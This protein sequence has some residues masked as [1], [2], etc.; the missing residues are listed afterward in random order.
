MKKILS[1][2]LT[3]MFLSACG[4]KA[5]APAENSFNE[6]K[7]EVVA[8]DSENVSNTS[9][10]DDKEDE[11]SKIAFKA[12]E[13]YRVEMAS[14]PGAKVNEDGTVS[15]MYENREK[16]GNFVRETNESSDWLAFG[17]ASR[18]EEL[19]D[20]RAIKLPD[21]TYRSYGLDATKGIQGNKLTSRSS[22]DGINFTDDEGARYTIQPEDN[23]SF[24][25]FDFFLDS[26]GG[27]VMT[28]IGDLYGE[29]NLRRA[30]STD[31]GWTFELQEKDIL[32]DEAAKKD[33]QRGSNVDQKVYA[34]DDGTFWMITMRQGSVYSFASDDDGVTWTAL[35]LILEPSD[36]ADLEIGSLHDPV[37]VFLP[38]GRIRIYVTGAEKGGA[39]DPSIPQHIISATS[40]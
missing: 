33:G 14:N 38:D 13:G 37:A 34:L 5:V 29:N 23:G 39:E 10:P 20:F 18:I 9:I 17:S 28:Y 8:S 32:G 3:F 4:N 7:G 40:I 25:V 11:N 27:V 35:G 1:V 19:G 12:D 22:K 31:N 30:Y 16:G 15:L 21:G 24:G 26:K 6:S 36:F 2:L